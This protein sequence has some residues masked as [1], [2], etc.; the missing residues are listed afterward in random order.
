MCLPATVESNF[1]SIFAL[2][3]RRQGVAQ[4]SDFEKQVKEHLVIVETAAEFPGMIIES[5][6]ADKKNIVTN[7]EDRCTSSY[8]SIEKTGISHTKGEVEQHNDDYLNSDDAGAKQKFDEDIRWTFELDL[9]GKCLG[10]KIIIALCET[11]LKLKSFNESSI[12]RWHILLKQNEL[13]DQCVR[14]LGFII[15]FCPSLALLVM[16][17]NNFTNEGIAELRRAV[18]E[19]EHACEVHYDENEIRSQASLNSR[20]F[21]FQSHEPSKSNAIDVSLSIRKNCDVLSS[22]Q[23]NSESK[24]LF[25]I[26]LEQEMPHQS[27]HLPFPMVNSYSLS[28]TTPV[29]SPTTCTAAYAIGNSEA[30]RR[31]REELF[32]KAEQI[33]SCAMHDEDKNATNSNIDDAS[34]AQKDL[35][36]IQASSNFIPQRFI[37]MIQDSH[38]LEETPD[39]SPLRRESE[40]SAIFWRS[41]HSSESASLPPPSSGTPPHADCKSVSIKFRQDET[42]E[43]GEYIKQHQYQPDDRPSLSFHEPFFENEELEFTTNLNPIVGSVLDLSR[44]VNNETCALCES[45]SHGGVQSVWDIIESH[46]ESGQQLHTLQEADHGASVKLPSFVVGCNN[47]SAITVLNISGNYLKR[48]Q[49]LPATLLQLDISNNDLSQLN[50]LNPCTMLTVLNARR[51]RIDKITGLERNTCLVRVFLGRNR[52]KAVEGLAHLLILETLDLS[53][54]QL[55]THSAV[56]ALSLCSSLMH[57]LLK[58]NPILENTTQS[59]DCYPMI[60][61]LCP[62]LLMIDSKKLSQSRFSEKLELQESH[63]RQPMLI[64]ST[65][66]PRIS[67][68]VENGVRSVPVPYSGVGKMG[69]YRDRSL[70]TSYHITSKGSDSS[71]CGTSKDEEASKSAVNLLYFLT[72]GAK[73]RKGYS[74][75]ARAANTVRRSTQRG[76]AFRE[77]EQQK[78]LLQQCDK[79]S[80]LREEMMKFLSGKSKK[81]LETTI[82]ERITQLQQ[83]RQR[84]ES[85]EMH[86]LPDTFSIRAGSTG[87]VSKKPASSIQPHDVI[88]GSSIVKS[89]HHTAI[90]TNSNITDIDIL[91]PYEP[92]RLSPPRYPLRAMVAPGLIHK[93]SVSRHTVLLSPE[94]DNVTSDIVQISEKPKGAS[95]IYENPC[96]TSEPFP[97]VSLKPLSYTQLYAFKRNLQHGDTFP[98]E[99]EAKEAQD[100][101]PFISETSVVNETLKVRPFD[102]LSGVKQTVSEC[103]FPSKLNNENPPSFKCEQ[104]SV[105]SENQEV[106]RI[107]TPVSAKRFSSSSSKGMS[108][109]PTRKPRPYRSDDALGDCRCLKVPYG[110]QRKVPT[111]S[112]C[113]DRSIETQ[114]TPGGNFH[115]TMSTQSL[116]RDAPLHTHILTWKRQLAKDVLAVQAALKSIMALL[117]TQ[118]S[119]LA[120]FSERNEMIRLTYL[121]ERQKCVG[122]I[123]RS[124]MLSDTE[125][126]KNIVQHYGFEKAELEGLITCRRKAKWEN[127]ASRDRMSVLQQVQ[128]LGDAKTCL[129]YLILLMDSDDDSLLQDYVDQI[130]E[131]FET[132]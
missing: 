61:N 18:H 52:I 65:H 54:N 90:S 4:P 51:N 83:Q 95:F 109:D 13:T 21:N 86:N 123:Q 100:G 82:V 19:T 66:Q 106:Y 24:N 32:G 30:L 64:D 129:R 127:K 120:G 60:R 3:L 93:K 47:Y 116:Y 8:I 125:I 55:R 91:K 38:L 48:L 130:K 44:A 89:R 12:I 23:L 101:C 74:D 63:M 103:S 17:E 1:I 69:S 35:L 112:Y 110:V 7:K 57:L 15:L 39:V 9:S 45:H 117:Q 111:V 42:T 124:G 88:R 27:S 104:L 37:D 76:E 113:I 98:I 102:I 75:T 53:Y 34:N 94:V 99:T 16:T 33:K 105:R 22:N 87:G 128:M 46:K 56:R 5:I 36:P 77:A 132:N 6:T 108:G 115:P 80:S 92:N 122:I 97:L 40:T 121:Q 79:K 68:N 119:N 31:R 85:K 62:S 71:A 72:H 50:G 43:G 107:S 59:K 41:T 78:M 70:H 58:G 26:S 2:E 73:P 28:R 131:T 96:M 49:T 126:P 20:R 11:L 25:A 118:W 81:Y 14:H 114:D 84:G 67:F 10:N 29:I